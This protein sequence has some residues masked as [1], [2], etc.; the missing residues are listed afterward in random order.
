MDLM[1]II[2]FYFLF[3]ILSSLFNIKYLTSVLE[4]LLEN[5]KTNKYFSLTI[6]FLIFWFIFCVPVSLANGFL[7]ILN[8]KNKITLWL[9]L[10]KNKKLLKEL[11]GKNK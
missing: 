9:M 10:R 11:I 4:K 5:Y 7:L 8:T 6:A 1:T 3:F 2:H